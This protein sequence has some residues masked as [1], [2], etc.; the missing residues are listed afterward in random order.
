MSDLT[1]LAQLLPPGSLN[2]LVHIGAGDGQQIEEYR[3]LAPQ[4]LVLVEGDPEAAAALSDRIEGNWDSELHAVVLSNRNGTAT[5]NR[6]NLPFLNGPLD[7]GPLEGMFPRL[8]KSGSAAVETASFEGFLNVLHP[9]NAASQLNV[10]FLDVPGQESALLAASRMAPIGG[11]EL[12]LIRSWSRP[13]GGSL[14]CGSEASRTLEALSYRHVSVRASENPLFTLRIW[15]LDR[16]A[17]ERAS[18][19]EQLETLERALHE[20]QRELETEQSLLAAHLDERERICRESAEHAA[21]ADELARIQQEQSER[22][23]RLGEE[24]DLAASHRAAVEAMSESRQ[25]E[26]ERLSRERDELMQ[27]LAEAESRESRTL[28]QV[29]EARDALALAVRIQ[30]QRE[31]DLADLQNRYRSL[32]EE[33]ASQRDLLTRVS[34]RLTLANEYFKQLQGRYDEAKGVGQVAKDPVLQA[35][36]QAALVTNRRLKQD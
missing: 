11:F 12:I 3:R 24:I 23:R 21:R 35:S 27:R 8:R 6:Y 2:T 1:Q 31:N 17:A 19:R 30:A 4:R 34:E 25:R 14:D 36:E 18:Y 9:A 13:W 10:L 32:H 16:D 26:N 15:R 5:W 29:E 28:R 33:N 20:A 7:C 22:I